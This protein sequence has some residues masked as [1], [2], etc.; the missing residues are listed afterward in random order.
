MN[1]QAQPGIAAH[2]LAQTCLD[3][4]LPPLCL[5]CG[6]RVGTNGA[7]CS[8]CWK[9]IA[10]ISPPLCQT[11]GTPF[12]IPL[13]DNS[14]CPD[15][16]D[17]PH[18]FSSARAAILYDK[19]S[20]NIVLGFKHGDRTHAAQALACWMA[21]AGECYW[22]EAD[23]IAPVPLHRWRL[24]K[25]RYN[26]SALLASCIAKM[27][28][29]QACLQALTRTRATQSQGHLNHKERHDNVTGAFIVSEREKPKIRNATIILIDDVMTTGAT[30]DECAKTLL[31]AGAKKVHALTLAR[32]RN[33]LS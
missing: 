1:W 12:N 30:L 8:D 15:C 32:V 22:K 25:R 14:L 23:I 9:N 10:F 18:I 29:K 33:R 2:R 24:F 19:A 17:T 26:Q 21:R 20:S 27:T 3:M 31:T 6:V 7:L 4:L 28:G 11:C 5:S 16:Q 13:A